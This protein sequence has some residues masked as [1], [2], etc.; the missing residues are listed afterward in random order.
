MENIVRKPNPKETR[1]NTITKPPVP[2]T[3]SSNPNKIS[4]KGK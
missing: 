3:N 4:P 2:P 1:G